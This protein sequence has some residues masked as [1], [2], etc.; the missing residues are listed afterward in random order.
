M[1]ESVVDSI[2]EAAQSYASLGRSIQIALSPR[3]PFVRDKKTGRN[4]PCPCGSDKK[5]KQ[6]CMNS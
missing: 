3:T 6:C 2:E 5:F 1:A 4:D